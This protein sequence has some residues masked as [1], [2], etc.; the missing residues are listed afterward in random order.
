MISPEQIWLA[1]EPIDMRLGIDG[2]SSK[3]IEPQ[4]RHGPTSRRSGRSSICRKSEQSGQ[5][6]K[7]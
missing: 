3:R 4:V 5:T 1:V 6:V 7:S 2:L